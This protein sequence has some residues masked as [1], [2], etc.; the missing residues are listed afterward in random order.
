MIDL[1]MHS[2]YSVDGSE[3]VE[4]MLKMAEQKKL[5]YISITDHEN[6]NSYKELKNMDIKK[7]Y[8]GKIIPGVEIKTMV[9]GISIELL[10]YYVEPEIINEELPK[11]SVPIKQ[12]IEYELYEF[13]DILEKKGV[14]LDRDVIIE[15]HK[16]KM[17]QVA[18][19]ENVEQYPENLEILK[20]TSFQE[21]G[22]FYRESIS[23]PNSEFY[24]DTS[25]LIPQVGKIIELIKSAGGL[26]FIPH[27][28]IYGNNSIKVLEEL[29]TKYNI[30]GIECYYPRFTE[31]QT[32]FLLDLCNEKGLYKSGGTDFHGKARPNITIGDMKVETN[33][34]SEWVKEG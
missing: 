13:M 34:I 23:N 22:K 9:A 20:G 12:I 18:V 27:V 21:D 32:K 26:V 29:T 6:C 16:Y 17:G 7:Y 25:H 2:M 10:G 4:T 30:D 24:I 14:K 28:F 5:E 3:T 33:I 8:S 1:H 11:I 31:E 19:R 15:N